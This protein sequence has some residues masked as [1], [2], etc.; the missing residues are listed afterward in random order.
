MELSIRDV[1]PADAEGLVRVLNPIIEAR[2]YTALDTPFS[3]DTERDYVI[4]FPDRGIWKVAVRQPDQAIVGFQV[5]E[6]YASYTHAFD[7]VGTLGT[8]VD[9]DLRRQGIARRLFAAT[10]DAARDKGYEKI[11]TFVRA[12]NPAALQ[13][14]LGQGFVVIGSAERQ[15]KIDGQYIDEILI[16]K[17]LAS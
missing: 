10:F 13:T 2:R 12:D 17:W 4:D 9:L 16:E 7:H 14:Y 15:A 11:F 8:Y 6:P 1:D 5:L 3:A